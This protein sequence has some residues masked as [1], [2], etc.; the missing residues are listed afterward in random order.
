ME[1]DTM[2]YGEVR[3]RLAAELTALLESCGE[4]RL[5][6]LDEIRRRIDSL[7]QRMLDAADNNFYS[8]PKGVLF[9]SGTHTAVSSSQALEQHYQIFYKNMVNKPEYAVSSSKCNTQSLGIG[10]F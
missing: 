9:D 8:P 4:K 1:Q 5:L 3:T 6:T 2:N 10:V 7:R